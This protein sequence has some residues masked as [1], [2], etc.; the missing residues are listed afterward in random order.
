MESSDFFDVKNIADTLLTLNKCNISK[1]TM[2][3]VSQS[4]PSQIA[5]KTT[6]SELEVWKVMNVLKRG[7]SV[8]DIQQ[9]EL[10]LKDQP[11]LSGEKKRPLYYVAIPSCRAQRVL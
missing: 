8:V 1:C 3:K 9:A 11:R 6:Y 2:L 5:I 7:K 10:H 4:H